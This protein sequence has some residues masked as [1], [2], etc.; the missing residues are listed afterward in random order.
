MSLRRGAGALVA[1]AALSVSAAACGGDGDD[2][3]ADSAAGQ[4]AAVTIDTFIFSPDPLE[5]DAGTTVTFTNR[6]DTLHTV[7]EGT[8]DRPVKGGFDL[9]LDGPGESGEITLDQPGTIT[10]ICDI[11]AGMDGTVVVR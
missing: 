1:A 7:T 5:V 11:H 10:Y 6:D 8:R 2:G 3:T 4:G 9:Q